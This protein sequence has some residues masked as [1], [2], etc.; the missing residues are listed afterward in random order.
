MAVSPYNDGD[1]G[2]GSSSGTQG[3]AMPEGIGAVHG[4]NDPMS[5]KTPLQP[6]GSMSPNRTDKAIS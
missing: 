6:L 5:M 4:F 1:L 3:G 2:G